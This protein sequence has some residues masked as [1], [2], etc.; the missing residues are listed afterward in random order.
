M[1]TRPPCA[2]VAAALPLLAFLAVS[3]C[4]GNSGPT[5]PDQS[6]IPFSTAE[7]RAGTGT[8]AA[9]GRRLIVNY[10][11]WLYSNTAAENK[12]TLFD[13]NV[14]RAAFAF[15]LGAGQVIPGWDQ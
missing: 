9:N 8:E 15:T 13:T 6:N 14:G 11:G 1:K 2:R 5:A 3:A 12:G 10:A 7:L 4:G